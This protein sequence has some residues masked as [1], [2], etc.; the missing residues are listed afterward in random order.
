MSFGGKGR[1]GL[2]RGEGGEW[3]R[4]REGVLAL[5]ER[6]W[7]RDFLVR[8]GSFCRRVGREGRGR[9]TGEWGEGFPRE[10]VG[11]RKKQGGD[12]SVKVCC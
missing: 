5:R 7:S 11:R 9:D 4:E 1:W 3:G 12:Q 8:G 6:V 10:E 2:G